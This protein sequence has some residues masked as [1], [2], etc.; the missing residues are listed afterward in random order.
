MWTRGVNSKVEWRLFADNEK[1][2]KTETQFSLAHLRS[3]LDTFPSNSDLTSFWTTCG[4]NQSLANI[5]EIQVVA[6]T[7]PAPSGEETLDVEWSSSMA[8]GVVRQRATA[9]A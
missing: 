3:S 5:Q 8:P 9:S 4:V 6:G 1:T 2:A 7:L